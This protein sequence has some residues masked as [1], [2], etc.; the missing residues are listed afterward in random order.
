MN[1]LLFCSGGL[2]LWC[3]LARFETSSKTPE[4]LMA[5][6]VVAVGGALMVAAVAMRGA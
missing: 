6:V 4:M 5:V 1:L 3:S 2:A